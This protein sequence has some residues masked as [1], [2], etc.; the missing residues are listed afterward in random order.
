MP[1]TKSHGHKRRH[2]FKVGDLVRWNRWHTDS[3]WIK[4]DGSITYKKQ[5]KSH[6]G[7]VL[8]VY[9]SHSKG[10]CW[11]AGIKFLEPE[12]DTSDWER[13]RPIPLSCLEVM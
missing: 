9:Q 3:D 10:R 12:L 8:E 6:L 11:M 2:L 1:R 5:V 7:I 4:V 13:A